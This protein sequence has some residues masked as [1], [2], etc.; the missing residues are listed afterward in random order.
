MDTLEAEV[1]ALKNNEIALEGKVSVLVAQNQTLHGQLDKATA[2]VER[3]KK[4]RA[5]YKKGID[6]IYTKL[7]PLSN[8]ASITPT[9]GSYR[10]EN[11]HAVNTFEGILGVL[12][13]DYLPSL[14]RET[15]KVPGVLT[16]QYMY[17]WRSVRGGNEIYQNLFD[18]GDISFVNFKHALLLDKSG[19]FVR[20]YNPD[21]PNPRYFDSG[22]YLE[23]Y[24]YRT[25]LVLPHLN[26]QNAAVK[27]TLINW[28][29][30]MEV[31]AGFLETSKEVLSELGS[32]FL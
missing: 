19:F 10:M 5:R 29:K 31:V 15:I 6:R 11:G 22:I 23:L 17:S 18:Q 30:R 16:P 13:T 32:T 3:L 12:P 7:L 9:T 26:A 2:N 4:E 24:K 14:T 20:G 1:K 21:P 27:T 25:S 8:A 28:W